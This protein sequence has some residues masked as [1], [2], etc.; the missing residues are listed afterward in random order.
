MK[1]IKLAGFYLLVIFY[2][3]AGLNH[4]INPS[5]YLPLIPPYFPFPE[6]INVL[7]GIAEIALGG[8]LIIP[9]TR[10]SAVIGILILLVAFLPAH[11]YLIQLDGCAGELCVPPWVAW[12]RLIVIHPLLILWAWAYR[13]YPRTTTD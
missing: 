9:A 1:I 13:N 4:F 2:M 3:L 10:R 8:M 12:V 7:S 6:L 5:F 11:I